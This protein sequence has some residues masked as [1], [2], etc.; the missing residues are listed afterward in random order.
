[1]ARVGHLSITATVHIGYTLLPQPTNELA[2]QP[3]RPC[4]DKSLVRA[5]A[6]GVRSRP[7]VQGGAGGER[8]FSP[9]VLCWPHRRQGPLP[10]V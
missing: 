4:D 3:H 5:P 8:P 7:C 10:T 6:M 2:W 1:M 9:H